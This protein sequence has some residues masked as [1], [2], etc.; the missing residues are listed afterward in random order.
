MLNPDLREVF[1]MH[2]NRRRREEFIRYFS[3]VFAA[4]MLMHTIDS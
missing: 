1:V 4:V 2:L 3:V